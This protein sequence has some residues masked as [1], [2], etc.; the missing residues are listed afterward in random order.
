MSVKC[1]VIGDMRHVERKRTKR[2]NKAPGEEGEV[3]GLELGRDNC[4]RRGR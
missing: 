1:T 2:R 4:E 3:G